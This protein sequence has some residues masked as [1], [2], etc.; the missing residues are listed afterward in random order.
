MSLFPGT[1]K[2]R[3]LPDD[4]PRNGWYGILPTPPPA[5]KV[6]GTLKADVAVIGAGTWGVDSELLRVML[7]LPKA[8]ILPPDPILRFIVNRG[9]DTYATTGAGER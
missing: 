1:R 5:R 8:A 7:S 4:G 3:I 6:A 9:I 2:A